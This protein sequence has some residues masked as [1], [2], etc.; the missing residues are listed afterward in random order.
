MGTWLAGVLLSVDSWLIGSVVI[1]CSVKQF[2]SAVS[3]DE[4]KRIGIMLKIEDVRM[5]SFLAL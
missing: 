5:L 1:Q 2:R 4:R 3:S